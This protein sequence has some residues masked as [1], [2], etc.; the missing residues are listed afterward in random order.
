MFSLFAYVRHKA[1]HVSSLEIN[2]RRVVDRFSSHQ[3]QCGLGHVLVDSVK[4]VHIM[5]VCNVRR[6]QSIDLTLAPLTFQSHERPGAGVGGVNRV[7]TNL[8]GA[9]DLFAQ[10]NSC[11]IF[12]RWPTI[13]CVPRLSSQFDPLTLI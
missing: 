4:N 8:L 7:E 5:L 2:H 1:R 13:L 10:V 12:A 6:R 11:Q 3:G 9:R